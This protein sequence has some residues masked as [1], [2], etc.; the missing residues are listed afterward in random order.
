LTRLG[1]IDE[2]ADCFNLTTSQRFNV[3]A[4]LST[5]RL[6]LMDMLHGENSRRRI[7]EPQQ[8]VTSLAAVANAQRISYRLSFQQEGSEHFST[9]Q[10][11]CLKRV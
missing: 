6:N 7:G 1:S 9:V 5:N 8:L 11:V 2:A 3:H 10:P 4:Q